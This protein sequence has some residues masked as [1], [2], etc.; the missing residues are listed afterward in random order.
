MDFVK[1]FCE[2]CCN[3]QNSLVEMNCKH[4]ICQECFKI[5][6]LPKEIC[7][8]CK[9][10]VNQIQFEN[11]IQDISQFE[12]LIEEKQDFFEQAY[13]ELVNDQFFDEDI[14]ILINNQNRGNQYMMRNILQTQFNLKWFIFDQISEQIKNLKFRNSLEM[15]QEINNLNICLNLIQLNNWDQVQLKDYKDIYNRQNMQENNK[16]IIQNKVS[17]NKKRKQKE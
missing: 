3:D 2:I 12:K 11:K 6:V 15:F 8:Y 16:F 1:E 9:Q 13:F 7:P 10:I 17:K 4:K 5:A 14:R